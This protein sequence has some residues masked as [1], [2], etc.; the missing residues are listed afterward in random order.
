MLPTF[1]TFMYSATD[2]LPCCDSLRAVSSATQQCTPR[3]PLYTQ[4][5][6]L[7]PK[8][9]T[10]IN[11]N[12]YS[13]KRIFVILGFYQGFLLQLNGNAVISIH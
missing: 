4:S 5:R 7:N 3:L 2:D 13:I 10:K 6:C 1:I 9:S 11:N 12:I 8:S